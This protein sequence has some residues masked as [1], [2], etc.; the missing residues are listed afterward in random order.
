MISIICR[1]KLNVVVEVYIIWFF[2]LSLFIGGEVI[3]ILEYL[4]LKYIR[5]SEYE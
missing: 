3:R 2:F 4:F 1:L 5:R